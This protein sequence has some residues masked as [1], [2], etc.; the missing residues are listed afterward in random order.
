MAT[1]RSPH[2]PADLRAL[3]TNWLLWGTVIA[4]STGLIWSLANW[5]EGITELAAA[6]VLAAIVAE[7]LKVKIYQ[8]RQQTL[9]F[10]LSMVVIMA[11]VTSEPLLGPLVGLTAALTHR[12]ANRQKEPV[13]SPS[14]SPMSAWRLGP[15]AWCIHCCGH[16]GSTS[17]W[18]TW[19]PR[20]SRSSR[21]TC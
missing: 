15:R 17:A 8:A 16:P 7:L 20:A 12:V 14:T 21:S 2:P 10:S 13:R 3:L 6:L 9:S 5:H 1:E 4:G 18:A 19:Q 11:A